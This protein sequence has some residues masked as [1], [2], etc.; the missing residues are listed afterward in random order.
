MKNKKIYI[1]GIFTDWKETT[2]KQ[3]RKYIKFIFE[4]I[5]T[6]KTD[7]KIKYINEKR[8]KGI[9]YEELFKGATL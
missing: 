4:N 5:T 1:K 9:K 3:A 7:K 2:P 8:L 6:M